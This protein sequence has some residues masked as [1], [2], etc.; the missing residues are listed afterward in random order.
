MYQITHSRHSN[1]VIALL[2][3]L[4]IACSL[5]LLYWSSL[6]ELVR[7]WEANPANSH[8]YLVPIVSLFFAWRAWRSGGPPAAGQIGTGAVALGVAE[9][10]LGVGF[11]FGSVFLHLLLWD[12]LSLVLVLR[13][14]LLI[15][16]GRDAI[17]NLG[18]PVLFLIFMAPLPV[19]CYQWITVALQ[20]AVSDI[21]TSVLLVLDVPVYRDGNVLHLPGY[22]MEVGA[23]CSGLTQLSSFVALTLVVA[24]IS[25]R[26]V[27]YKLVLVAMAVPIAVAANCVRVS[28][29]GIILVAAGPKWAEGT[30]HTLEGL[31]I[32]GLGAL[33]LMLVAWGLGKLDDR[34]HSRS[35]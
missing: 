29:T 13:G 32:V 35:K 5:V 1:A 20:Q 26:R 22:E 15:L 6:F 30:F 14:L 8:G 18:F 12:V 17:R 7:S 23:A 2:G 16:G 25:E 10:A 24:H 9:L 19:S 21:S 31:A 28:V 33:L 27:W 3:G 4:Y 34:F 11:R